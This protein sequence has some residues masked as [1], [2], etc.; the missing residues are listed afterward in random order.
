[1]PRLQKEDET[2]QKARELA[3][4]LYN[5]HP[6]CMCSWDM[7]HPQLQEAW[8]RFAKFAY[9]TISVPEDS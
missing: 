9:A 5:K 7:L 1:M 6:G 3:K 2:E 4:Q 8:V